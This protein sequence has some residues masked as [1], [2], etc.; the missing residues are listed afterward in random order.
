M[1]VLGRSHQVIHANATLLAV[2][3]YFKE[4]CGWE[5]NCFGFLLRALS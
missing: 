4:R 3:E 1:L 2:T 5:G